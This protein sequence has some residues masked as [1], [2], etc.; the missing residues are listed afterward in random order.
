VLDCTAT[1]KAGHAARN[2]GE[3]AIYKAMMDIEWFQRYQF[4]K[5]SDLL[6]PVKMSVT[7]IE[8]PTKLTTSYRQRVGMW[9]TFGSM[10]SIRWKR[11][12]IRFNR[13]FK[14]ALKPE[15]SALDH[16]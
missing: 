2:E 8:T 13:L 9:W 16:Q 10:N 5:I 4:D 11:C 3:N 12:C 14:A 7:S 1:G 6:G 15:A